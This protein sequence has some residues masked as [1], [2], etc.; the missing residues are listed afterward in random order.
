MTARCAVYMGALK[1]FETY[2]P[3]AMYTHSQGNIQ[4]IG[5]NYRGGMGKSGVLEHKSG[6]ISEMRI[7]IE[8]KLPWRAYM[9]S[10]TL[11]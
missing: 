3:K 7:K 2:S 4:K 8:E 9:K 6:N 5:G 10:P 1:T 11:F